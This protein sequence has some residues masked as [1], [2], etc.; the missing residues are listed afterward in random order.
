MGGLELGI[1]ELARRR[2]ALLEA[3]DAYQTWLK[4]HGDPGAFQSPRLAEMADTLRHERLTLAFVAEFS[5]GKTELINAL[6]FSD[7]KQRLLP[8]DVGRTTMCPTEIRYD[9]GEAPSLRLLPVETRAHDDSIT[10]YRLRLQEW[11]LFPLDTEDPAQIVVTLKKLAETKRLPVDEAR[12]LG[13]SDEDMPVFGD[14][15]EIPAWRYAIINFP[16]PWLE[17]G[18]AILDTPGL[19]A[20]GAEPELTLSVIPNAHAVLFLLAT[21]TGVTRSDLDI[22]NKHLREPLSHHLVVLNKVDILWD[23]LK[24]EAE[25]A[26]TIQRQISDTARLLGV[27][28]SRVVAISAQKALVGRIRGDASLLARSG[29]AALEN[30]LCEEIL[31]SRQQMLQEGVMRELSGMVDATRQAVEVRAH[32]LA[33]D[34][35]QLA[36]STGKTREAAQQLIVT[37]EADRVRVAEAQQSFA[38][39]GNL[40]AQRSENLLSYLSPRRIDGLIQEG[41]EGIRGAMTTAGLTRGMRALVSRIAAQYDEAETIAAGIRDTLEATYNRFHDRYGFDNVYPPPLNFEHHRVRL[42]KLIEGAENFCSDR[43]NMLLGKQNMMRKFHVGLVTQARLLL[44]QVRRDA[45]RWLRIGLDPLSIR[46]REREADLD[47]RHR[48]ATDLVDN[49]EAAQATVAQM[50]DDIKRMAKSQTAI[51][52]VVNKLRA[53]RGEAL[54]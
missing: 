51:T 50:K 37:I 15:A 7:F 23:D 19:N 48:Q 28:E 30:I 10:A 20:L 13:F 24:T 43:A 45:E 42:E 18:L 31:P 4:A 6:F 46:I 27:D 5:R 40:I 8:S 36:S 2:D 25:V 35:R 22:W 44:D 16:H 11:M 38:I 47:V 53:A 17:S 41:V 39:T 12:N 3:I 52:A 26:A 34:Y 33:Q 29:I 1:Q 9:R 21:D 54:Y 32:T 14:A 49:A